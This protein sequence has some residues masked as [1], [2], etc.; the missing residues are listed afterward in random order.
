MNIKIG[1]KVA[2][3]K[4]DVSNWNS[5]PKVDYGT[6]FYFDDNIIGCIRYNCSPDYIHIN[7]VFEKYFFIGVD[8]K[9]NM[10]DI[11]NTE[12]EELKSQIKALTA[13]EKN[14]LIKNEFNKVKEQIIKTSE[15]FRNGDDS[16]FINRLKAVCDLKKKLFSIKVSDLD[17]IH[18]KNGSIKYKIK[19]LEDLL[20][21]IDE[22]EFN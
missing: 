21:K 1:D 15:N 19:K 22:I 16:D 5:Y 10:K 2:Y 8:T 12:I 11:I 6:V 13:D 3:L 18:K 4:Y 20:K 17:N 7:S 9:Q 14:E